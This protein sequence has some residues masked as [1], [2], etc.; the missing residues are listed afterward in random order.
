MTFNVLCEIVGSFPIVHVRLRISIRRSCETRRNRQPCLA[1]YIVVSGMAIMGALIATHHA[2][3]AVVNPST[4][5]IFILIS[6]FI[7]LVVLW[8]LPPACRSSLVGKACI[9][10]ILMSLIFPLLLP[11]SVTTILEPNDISWWDSKASKIQIWY[12]TEYVRSIAL[13]LQ[14][15]NIVFG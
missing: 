9:K 3:S 12:L 8:Q 10:V 6:H 4:I 1:H 5:R 13:P 14:Q 11:P 2:W 7:I 15:R